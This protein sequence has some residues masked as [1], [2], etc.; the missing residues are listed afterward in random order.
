MLSTA[1]T[2]GRRGTFLM[3]MTPTGTIRFVAGVP[4][5]TNECWRTEGGAAKRTVTAQPRRFF[6]KLRGLA[7]VRQP[8]IAFA[9]ER[10]L[11]YGELHLLQNCCRRGASA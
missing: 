2:T 1:V 10:D 4:T 3:R 8:W 9:S 6:D 11:T 7:A 5:A